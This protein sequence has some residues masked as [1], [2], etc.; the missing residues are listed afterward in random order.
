MAKTT[1]NPVLFDVIRK[2]LI[3]EKSTLLSEHNKATFQ[4]SGTATKTQIKEAVEALF[5]AKVK[6]VNT[7]N[8]KGKV[9]RFR[10]KIG[11]RPD[12][13]KAVVTLEEGQSIDFMAGVK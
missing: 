12:T 1:T 7:L 8:V 6:S 4:V 5:G 3:T 9:K 10:G 2:P 13:K 11:T